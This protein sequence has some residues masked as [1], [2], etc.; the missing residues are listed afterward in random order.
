MA[1]SLEKV[2]TDAIDREDDRALELLRIWANALVP[3]TPTVGNLEWFPVPPH[4]TKCSLLDPYHLKYL[5]DVTPPY[6]P[7]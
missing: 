7:R 2:P 6:K 1:N 4:F 3:G 5:K